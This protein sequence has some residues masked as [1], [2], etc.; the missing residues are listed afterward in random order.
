MMGMQLQ[1]VERVEQPLLQLWRVQ[2]LAGGE[3]CLF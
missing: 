3:G 2:L 1:R